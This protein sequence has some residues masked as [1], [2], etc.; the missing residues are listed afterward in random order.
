MAHRT[1]LLLKLN[2][3]THLGHLKVRST[4]Y[5][6]NTFDYTTRTKYQ[7]F[8]SKDL[9]PLGTWQMDI[10]Q[11][12]WPIWLTRKSQIGLT[13]KIYTKK[14]IL[15]IGVPMT[16]I[17][18]HDQRQHLK[19]RVGLFIFHLRLQ[20]SD[21][22]LSLCEVRAGTEAEAA[23]KCCLHACYSYFAY[24]V[25]LQHQRLTSQNE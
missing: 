17:N 20:F 6:A 11:S 18:Q 24:P 2:M 16:T 14:E 7:C 1:G 21:C 9:C 19:E 12:I 4:Q 13:N 8:S 23:E 25:I 5:S 15:L 22:N 3:I 10:C